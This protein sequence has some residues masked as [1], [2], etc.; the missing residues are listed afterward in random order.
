MINNKFQFQTSHFIIFATLL[1]TV[2]ETQRPSNPNSI[3]TITYLRSFNPHLNSP[4]LCCKIHVVYS[5]YLYPSTLKDAALVF[6]SSHVY[7]LSRSCNPPSIYLKIFGY[8]QNYK[9]LH[10]AGSV[11]RD[12]RN[13]WE[14]NNIIVDWK[15]N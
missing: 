2:I 9:L 10:Q 1:F 12:L 14:R 7:G 8:E 15:C 4:N 3:Y 13:K 11:A 5:G 6:N